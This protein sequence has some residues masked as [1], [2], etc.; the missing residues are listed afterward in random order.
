MHDT[1]Y[2]L[3]VPADLAP[4]AR[5]LAAGLSPRGIG[6]F[7]TAVSP[8]GQPPA[9]GYISAGF[10]EHA[11]GGLLTNADALYAACQAAGASVSLAQCQDLV[12]RSHVS[13]EQP[14]DMMERVGVALVQEA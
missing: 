5:A 8:T 11:I 7:T 13:T 10:I 12:T 3:I 2:S 6:M 1:H 9:T 4:L 14:F